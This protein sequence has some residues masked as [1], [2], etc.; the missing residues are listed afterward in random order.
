MSQSPHEDAEV[1]QADRSPEE[2]EQQDKEMSRPEDIAADLGYDFEIKEQDRWLPIANGESNL[3]LWY[4]SVSRR[5]SPSLVL[6]AHPCLAMV[7]CAPRYQLHD[8]SH[9]PI[10]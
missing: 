5:M 9:G 10:P 2:N 7:S 3:Q 6:Q 8:D 4:H 1:E